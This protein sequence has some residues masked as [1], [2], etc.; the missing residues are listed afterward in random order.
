MQVVIVQVHVK[1]ECIEAFK[2]ASKANSA[3]SLREPGV[4]RFDVLQH[5]DDPAKFVLYEV[6]RTPEAVAA[7]KETA[8]Y[9]L[10]RD[11]VANMMAAPRVGTRCQ[12]IAPQDSSW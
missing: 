10:W 5:S 2:E 9:A 7:H 3:G 6:Y 11:T 4:A 12:S 1:P 8:H